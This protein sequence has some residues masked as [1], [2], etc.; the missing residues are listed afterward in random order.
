MCLG[1]EK[2]SAEYPLGGEVQLD[3]HW[4]QMDLSNWQSRG[5]VAPQHV[6]HAVA[7]SV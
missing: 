3:A 4:L 6:L 5:A 1:S 2:G 7:H